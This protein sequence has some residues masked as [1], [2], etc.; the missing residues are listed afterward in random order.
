MAK[1]ILL[2]FTSTMQSTYVDLQARMA[3]R[4]VVINRYAFNSTPE[5][6]AR[7]GSLRR[8]PE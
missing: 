3:R 2:D 4:G 7:L 1:T 8:H 6:A 5:G